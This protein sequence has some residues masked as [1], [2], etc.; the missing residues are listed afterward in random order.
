MHKCCMSVWNSTRCWCWF[1]KKIPHQ[2]SNLSTRNLFG[3]NYFTP[4]VQLVPEG[5]DGRD[6][7][8]A[9][10]RDEEGVSTTTT[11]QWE[12]VWVLPWPSEEK[13]ACC[14]LLLTGTISRCYCIWCVTTVDITLWW[15]VIKVQHFRFTMAQLTS[16]I[17]NVLR[18]Y[19]RLNPSN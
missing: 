17:V 4:G 8:G 14:T 16:V 19:R 12:H 13:P 9:N 5:R 15:C 11:N 18:N 3:M 6:H 1:R 10:S 7:A 2:V